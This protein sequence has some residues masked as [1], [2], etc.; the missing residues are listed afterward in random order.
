MGLHILVTVWC[1]HCG[2]ELSIPAVN[3]DDG[4]AVAVQ[5]YGWTYDQAA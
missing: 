3:A 1:D 5:V 2:R 4:R